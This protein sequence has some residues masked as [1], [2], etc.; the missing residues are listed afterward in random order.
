MIPRVCGYIFFYFAPLVPAFKGPPGGVATDFGCVQNQAFSR[1]AGSYL[2][3][4]GERMTLWINGLTVF[5][6][7]EGREVVVQFAKRTLALVILK[8]AL[9][10][11]ES[12]CCQQ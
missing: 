4:L 8:P 2:R 9:S 6:K 1:D 11:E 10:V 3:V 12:A 7:P 5:V